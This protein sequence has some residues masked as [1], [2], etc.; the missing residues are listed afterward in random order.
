MTNLYVDVPI[1]QAK[2]F[3]RIQY[4]LRDVTW[5]QIVVAASFETDET[6]FFIRLLFIR[7]TGGRRNCIYIL[8]RC[9]YCYEILRDTRRHE[10]WLLRVGNFEW[11]M[12]LTVSFKVPRNIK[13]FLFFKL[14]NWVP[15]RFWFLSH[16]GK[17]KS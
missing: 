5:E 14:Y 15:R 2:F 1:S 8:V 6:D 11:I 10:F 17:I 3:T 4:S 16:S 12:P 9:Y 13:Q 7:S